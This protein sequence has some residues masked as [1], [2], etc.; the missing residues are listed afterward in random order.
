MQYRLAKSLV[1]LRAQVDAAHP[2]RA[3]F[4]DGW[5]GDTSHQ[6]RKSDHNPNGAGVVQAVDLSHDPAHGFD[7]Y[8]FADMLRQKRDPRI[9]YVISHGRIF[10]SEVHAWEWRPYTGADSHSHH[11]HISVS[12]DPRQYDLEFEWDIS[13]DGTVPAVPPPPVAPPDGVTDAVRHSMAKHIL[14]FEARRDHAG[15]LMVYMLPAND[16]G[17]RYEVAGINEKYDGPMAAKLKAMVERGQ[18]DAAETEAE[19]YILQ[20]TN[21]ATSWTTNA[22]VESYLRDCVFNRGA[23]GAARILQH[24]CGVSSTWHDKDDDGQIGPKSRGAIAA[25]APADLLTKLRAAREAYERN[26]VGY[27]ANFWNGL[28]SRWDKSLEVARSYL[29]G[30]AGGI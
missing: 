13:P 14:D 10:S 15:H 17:G 7:S 12:D 29:S 3:K 27:R 16:G 23:K 20:N 4:N 11:V 18:F 6:A 22:G 26:I 1:T 24:A 8:A 5:I 9:K 21:P 2:D 19:N 25:I 28:V 30:K